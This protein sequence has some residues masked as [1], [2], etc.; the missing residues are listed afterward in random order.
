MGL[1]CLLLMNRMVTQ[2]TV[3]W[4]R[5]ILFFA[6]GG[7]VGNFTLSLADHATN[8]FFHWTEWIPVVSSA[9]AVGVLFATFVAPITPGFRKA[10]LAVMIL[11]AIVGVLGFVLHIQ[12][13]LHGPSGRLID[14]VLSG[15]P[16][17]A[18]LLLPN[19]ALLA[20]IG[21]HVSST[22]EFTADALTPNIAVQSPNPL[23][24]E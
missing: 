10:C 11:Q 8:G 4:S 18:P 5:W 9:L 1:G 21:L 17:F 2:A 3:E 15:A 19:L 13:D 22:E 20:W 23:A 24:P 6:L 14:N 16:P 12:A 7:F